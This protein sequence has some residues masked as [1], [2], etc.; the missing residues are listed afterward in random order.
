M[1]FL[2]GVLLGFVAGVLAAAF[3]MV[4]ADMSSVRRCGVIDLTGMRR[5]DTGCHGTTDANWRQARNCP[6][7]C[8]RFCARGV[9]ADVLRSGRVDA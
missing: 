7:G 2:A 6:L 9:G 4:V 3:L 5:E 1:I 8:S